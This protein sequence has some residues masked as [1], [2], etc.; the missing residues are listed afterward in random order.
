VPIGATT[1][2]VPS[3]MMNGLDEI[4]VRQPRV[5]LIN[6]DIDARLAGTASHEIESVSL[7]AL[8]E[9]LAMMCHIFF[10]V[11][12]SSERTVATILANDYFMIAVNY[13]KRLTYAE[14]DQKACVDML[15]SLLVQIAK[16]VDRK[17]NEVRPELVAA[18]ILAAALRNVRDQKLPLDGIRDWLV[19]RDE[20][21]ASLDQ[22][23]TLPAI[24]EAV[25][26]RFAG[27]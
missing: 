17:G 21:Y 16:D 10:E 3:T 20:L 13:I 23:T 5:E 7:R 19:L 22:D 9:A 1:D 4:P 27:T 2:M 6:A 12:P 15:A 24:L 26:H 18:Y 8:E 14:S 11:R 25:R